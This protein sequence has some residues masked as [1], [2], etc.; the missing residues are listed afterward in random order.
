M[1]TQ[2][3]AASETRDYLVDTGKELR[4]FGLAAGTISSFVLSPDGGVASL[5]FDDFFFEWNRCGRNP[6]GMT[7]RR[8]TLAA[9]P[10][11]A[12][13]PF[14]LDLRGALLPEGTAGA[15]IAVTIDGAAQALSLPEEPG[16]T[17]TLTGQL[18]P[19]ERTEVVVTL[20]LPQPAEGETRLLTIDSIDV[21]FPEAA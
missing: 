17:L 15:V 3:G 19:G 18:A 21:Y 5:L 10:A 14:R 16:F 2:A 6:A 13:K 8:F 9:T 20:E 1:G 12:G 11:A 4:F 7:T